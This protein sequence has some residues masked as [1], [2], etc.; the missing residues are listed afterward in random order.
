MEN[1]KEIKTVWLVA[2]S[3]DDAIN[4]EWN[5]NTIGSDLFTLSDN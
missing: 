5:S 4:K 2:R 1:G 3:T